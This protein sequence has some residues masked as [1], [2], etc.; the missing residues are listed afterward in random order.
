MENRIFTI[1]KQGSN[2]RVVVVYPVP[3]PNEELQKSTQTSGIKALGVSKVLNSLSEIDLA[4]AL[5]R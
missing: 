3:L 1:Y 4:G 5:L 2:M